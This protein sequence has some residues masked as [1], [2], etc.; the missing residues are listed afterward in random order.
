MHIFFSVGEPS[1]DQHAAHLMHELQA[2]EPDLRVSGF[3]GPLMEDAGLESL[4]RLTNLAVMGLVKVLP[5]IAKFYS[6]V[7]QAE[8]FFAEQK[9]DAV[10]LVDFPGFNWWIAK[11]AKAAGIP[12]FYYLPPQLWAWAPWR[13]SRVRKY[14]D[15]VISAL[16]FERDWYQ[17]RGIAVDYVGH[18]FFDEVAD[19][20][21]DSAFV[22]KWR[23]GKRRIVAL[24]PG[25]RNQEVSSNWPLMLEAA[26]RLHSD[27]PDVTFLVACFRDQH[28]RV[29]QT[30]QLV[31]CPSVPMQFFV[32]KTSEIVEVADCAIMVSGSVSLELLARGTPA[33]VVYRISWL[34]RIVGPLLIRCRFM[35]LPNLLADREVMPEYIPVGDLEP[36]IHG[37]H[38]SLSNWLATPMA[39]EQA[40]QSL[41]DTGKGFQETGATARTAETILRHLDATGETET[42]TGIAA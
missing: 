40:R 1:G 5:L 23:G 12:V 25:S 9:P 15:Y 20:P 7:K 32:G 38:T 42:A 24:L 11:K 4:Y 37:L 29:C 21:L 18:P 30:E 10:V 6:L 26:R 35:S 28:R 14:V 17:Q 2:R 27:H 34:L 3:G 33:A 22:E 13:I 16:P 19:H 31:H 8:R 41:A 39:L 36:A